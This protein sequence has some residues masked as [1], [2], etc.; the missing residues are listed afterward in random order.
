MT[1]ADRVLTT[2]LFSPMD[3]VFVKCEFLH[4]GRSHKA[5][6]AQ[7]LVDDVEARGLVRP[8][9]GTVLLERTGGNLGIALAVEARTRGYRLE[10]VTDPHYSSI[11]RAIAGR[12]GAHVIDRGASF[13]ECENNQQVVD[14][15]MTAAPGRYCYL[16][17]F[18]NPANPAAH[19]R[20]TGAEIVAQLQARGYDR[21]TTVVLVG[22]LGTGAS[23]R[24]VSDALR[25]WFRTVRTVGVQP[26][27]C[28]L[29]AGEYGEHSV[30][31][32]AV[33]Q[34]PPFFDVRRLDAVLPVME[35]QLARA[36]AHLEA[37]HRFLVG[38]SSA[39]NFAVLLA[40][41]DHPVA[42]APGRRVLVTLLYDRG[43][44]YE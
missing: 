44:D 3:D 32:I 18:G 38:P 31:G 39:A 20:G 9:G 13:P 24:G 12:L 1:T 25:R 21:D 36:A 8:D 42:E 7:A 22:G 11:K 10:L 4:P 28:D 27:H 35:E 19:E 15:L 34:A 23:M 37:E 2:P 26:P 41:R 14:L 6:V 16:N 40:A 43:E 30:Q 29:L 17:Q 5:R 33:G